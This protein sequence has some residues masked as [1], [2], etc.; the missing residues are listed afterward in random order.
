MREALIAR[1]LDGCWPPGQALPSEQKLA[2]ELGVSQ[3]TVRKA[4]DSLAADN[5]L[6]RRQGLGTFV[7]EPEETGLNFK[8][9]RL[10]P[11][12]GPALAPSSRLI[13]LAKE[14]ADPEVRAS[15]QLPPRASVWRLGRVRFIED[16]P[17]IFETI[18]L[19]ASRFPQL[20]RMEI[21]NNLYRLYSSRFGITIAH[22]VE[23][24]KA[25]VATP[26]DVEH[27]GCS[28]RTPLLLIDR[29]AYGLDDRP[30]ERRLSRCLTER[31]HYLSDLR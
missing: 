8:F 3:G 7:A 16:L 20:D 4:L 30:I 22:A 6:V 9:F 26:E 28:P 10:A 21:P 15:L 19:S 23:R 25:V 27:L 14:P 17:A 1:L 24:L 29:V 18:L 5:L 31:L 11:D 2:Q 13:G 12:D